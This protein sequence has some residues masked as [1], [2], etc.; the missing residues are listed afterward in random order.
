MLVFSAIECANKVGIYLLL[1]YCQENIRKR[2]LFKKV[3]ASCEEEVLRCP[4]GI[5]W[6]AESKN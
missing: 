1:T 2:R 6:Y 4:L 5:F 3:Q